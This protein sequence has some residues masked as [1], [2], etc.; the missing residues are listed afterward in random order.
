[1]TDLLPLIVNFYL[2]DRTWK[3]AITQ[4]GGTKIA[5]PV[6]IQFS[7]QINDLDVGRRS[8]VK[9]LAIDFPT[10]VLLLS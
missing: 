8:P 4:N 9:T 6:E 5:I 10:Y 3:R 1:M 7:I 2:P